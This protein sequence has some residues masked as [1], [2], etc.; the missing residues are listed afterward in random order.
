MRPEDRPAPYI[1]TTIHPAQL[2]RA[3][4]ER[5]AEIERAIKARQ[6]RDAEAAE[7][8]ERKARERAASGLEQYR[9]EQRM[10]WLAAAGSEDGF[11]AAWP[12]LRQQYVLERQNAV[13]KAVDELR[14]AHGTL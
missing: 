7:A 13:D 11:S 10:R 3:A 4:A 1:Q 9:E 6:E 14:A 8:R 2:Q 5:R 12:S